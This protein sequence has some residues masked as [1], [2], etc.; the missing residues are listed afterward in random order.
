MHCI[1]DLNNPINITFRLINND[2]QPFTQSIIPI[3]Y[4]HVSLL[5]KAKIPYFLNEDDQKCFISKDIISSVSQY[6]KAKI[7]GFISGVMA[8]DKFDGELI[9]SIFELAKVKYSYSKDGFI[10]SGFLALRLWLLS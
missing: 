10:I 3:P 4:N 7:N 2:R 8:N 5:V 9:R 6:E 1:L